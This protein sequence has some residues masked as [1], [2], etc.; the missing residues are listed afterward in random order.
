ML[1]ML[2]DKYTEQ[3]KYVLN[4]HSTCHVMDGLCFPAVLPVSD[5]VHHH[6]HLRTLQQLLL[7]RPYAGHRHGLQDRPHHPV[8]RYPQ[9]KAGAS[10]SRQGA[11]ERREEA[12]GRR[13]CG[14]AAGPRFL[15][16]SSL[17]PS[18]NLRGF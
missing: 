7:R 9:W 13:S 4:P 17:G 15:V 10:L 16:P 1:F 14:R 11:P 3:C 6:V 18:S 2:E 8:F 12:S 5:L